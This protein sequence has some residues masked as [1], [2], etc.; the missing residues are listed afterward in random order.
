MTRLALGSLLSR[1]LRT[2]LTI[3]AILLWLSAVAP[4]AATEPNTTW[5]GPAPSAMDR[6]VE[7]DGDV[8]D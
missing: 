4:P 3:V 6:P 8:A 5:T 7:A 2:T 1:R